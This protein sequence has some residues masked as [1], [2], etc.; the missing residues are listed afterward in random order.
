[1]KKI[2]FKSLF[3][4]FALFV[5]TSMYAQEDVAYQVI[6]SSCGGTSVVSAS[7]SLDAVLAE[8]DRIEALC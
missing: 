4:L 5:A 6:V 7:A 1:M 2:N 8:Y 3:L